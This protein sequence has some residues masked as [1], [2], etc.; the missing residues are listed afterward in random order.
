MKDI[1]GFARPRLELRDLQVVLAV[2]AAGTTAAAAA[3]LHLSQPAVSRALLAAED[4]LGARLFERSP[5]GLQLTAAGEA[6]AAGASRLLAEMAELE[7]QVL[8]PAAPPRRVR[9]VCECYTAYHWLPSALVDLR[10]SLPGLDVTLAVEHTRAP[11]EALLR[12]AID[13]ALLTTAEVPRGALATQPLFADEIVFV[14]APSHPLADRPT[15]TRDD[16]RAARLLCGESPAAETAWFL[17]RVF[18]RGRRPQPAERFPLTEALL[19]VARAG[20][21]VAVLSEWIA[22]PHL[23]RG[24]LVVKRLKSGPL[25]RPW[26]MA[27]RREAADAARPLLAALRPAAPGAQASR[28][29]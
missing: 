26:R 8:A 6:L 10:R 16:L 28:A 17:A 5:R 29:K 1:T 22:A 18:G 24:G 11:V 21:G 13:V 2:A 14:V 25:R 15:I 12:G 4:R 20:M 9:L 19:D 3:T 23:A 27:W 7:R